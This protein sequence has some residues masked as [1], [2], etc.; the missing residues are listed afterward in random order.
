MKN[1]MPKAPSFVVNCPVIEWRGPAPFYFAKIDS[2]TSDAIKAQSKNYVYGWG[3]LYA[4]GKVGKTEFQ[5][6]LMPKDGHYLIP[7][8]DVLRKA[9]GIELGQKLKFLVTLGKK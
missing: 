2:E 7:L 5:T 6:T 3:V 8:K 1:M 4:H 9:E